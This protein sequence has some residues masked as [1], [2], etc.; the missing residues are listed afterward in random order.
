MSLLANHRVRPV[1]K[2]LFLG[3]LT[4][5]GLGSWVAATMNLSYQAYRNDVEKLVAERRSNSST[6]QGYVAQVQQE[7]ALEDSAFDRIGNRRYFL[8]WV[9]AVFFPL[10]AAG[11]AYSASLHGSFGATASRKA[12]AIGALIAM[13]F[14]T[15]DASSWAFTNWVVVGGWFLVL[16]LCA[17]ALRHTLQG[18]ERTIGGDIDIKFIPWR[19]AFAATGIACLVGF[20][21]YLNAAHPGLREPALPPSWAEERD[22]TTLQTKLEGFIAKQ[23]DERKRRDAISLALFVV[24]IASSGIG[25]WGMFR[26]MHADESANVIVAPFA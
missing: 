23:H 13:L 21:G 16:L 15:A 20:A 3:C 12:L 2:A 19:A 18:V 1:L 8:A 25:F 6:P 7:H 14:S 22:S 26:R 5:L 11:L 17:V 10:L 24:G 9:S 4:M